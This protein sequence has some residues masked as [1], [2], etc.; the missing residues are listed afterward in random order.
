[1]LLR[2]TRPCNFVAQHVEVV[3]N[4]RTAACRAQSCRASAG[5]HAMFLLAPNM[6]ACYLRLF[7]HF[8]LIFAACS[9]LGYRYSLHASLSPHFS[10]LTSQTVPLKCF[11]LQVTL[12][13]FF[14]CSSSLHHRRF[15]SLRRCRS[16]FHTNT[17]ASVIANNLTLFV[18]SRI[19][20]LAPYRR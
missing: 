20:A 11:P 10:N 17:R 19:V 12:A 5:L 1:M 6:L 18:V 13:T 7:S 4:R 8:L 9:F 16:F 3:V 2:D 14:T 15:C